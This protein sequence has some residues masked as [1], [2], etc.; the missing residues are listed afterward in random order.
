M[1]Q[2]LSRPFWLALVIAAFCVPLFI[3]LGRT[4]VENDEGIYSYAVD[5]ILATGDW[6]NPL[7]S[8]HD[9]VVFLEKPPLKFWIVAAPIRL[10]LLPH[11]EFGL[12]FWDALFGAIGFLYVFVIGRRLA[13]VVCGLIAVM[14]LFVYEP[15]LFEHGLRGNNMEA[16][17]FLCYCGGVYHYIAW[18]TG[19]DLR[20]RW[21]HVMAVW[22]YFFLGFMT[23]FVAAFFLPVL[24]GA[25]S[26]LLPSV[27]RRLVADLRLWLSAAGLVVALSAPW[28]IYQ[29]FKSGGAVWTVMFGLHVL[30]RF[31]SSLDVSHVHP[32]HY[33]WVTLWGALFHMGT[34]WLAVAGFVLLAVVAWRERRVE[35]VTV[36]AWLVVPLTLMSIGTSKL[37]HYLYPFI[38]PAALAIGFG[39]GWI[40]R[41]GAGYLIGSWKSSSGASPRAAAGPCDPARAARPRDGRGGACGR[42]PGARQRHLAGRRR[43]DHAQRPCRAAAGDRP[44][45]GDPCRPRGDGGAAD[46]PGRPADAGAADER[47]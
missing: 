35:A 39:P 3:G 24:L 19:D 43:A 9:D 21:R 41:A 45:S 37:H 17:L 7:A 28:F 42:D 2:G 20:G 38:P 10:G 11:D 23:K 44:G 47:L 15:L 5:G 34:A 36:I 4:D 30:T 18:A 6:L 1:R 33:Y 16:P 40:A 27:R 13:G 25:T 29:H 14:V 31:T 46:L 8:P 22:L 32:W 26:L 12:R